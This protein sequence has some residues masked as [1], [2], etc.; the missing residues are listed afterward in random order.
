MT[1]ASAAAVW[2]RFCSVGGITTE[3]LGINA[4][5]GSP[6][7]QV[8]VLPG[9]PGSA[10]FFK[11]FMAAVHRQLRGRADVLALT[12]AGHDPE[13]DHGG[14]VWDLSQQINHKVSFLREHVL[15]PGKPPVLL[16]G[17]SIGAAMMIKAVAE[18]E[19]LSSASASSAGGG[20]Q[21]EQQ[22]GQGQGCVVGR[23]NPLADGP[24][25][26]GAEVGEL[27]TPTP[28]PT[29]APTPPAILKLVAVFPFFETNFRGSWRQRC[30]SS[31]A[32]W[33]EALGWA[34]AAV[35]SLPRALQLAFVRLGED[36]D[37][38]A[39]AL[40]ARLLSRRTVCNAFFLASHEFRDLSRPWDWGLMRVLGRRLHVMGCEADTWMSRQQYDNMLARVPG[41]Q[42]TWHP[43]LRHAF[44]VSER[45]S[46]AVAETIGDVARSISGLDLDLDLDLDVKDRMDLV[47]ARLDLDLD[48][49]LGLPAD[50]VLEQEIELAACRSPRSA[51]AASV[52]RAD[53]SETS[54]S[55]TSATAGAG[56]GTGT[57]NDDE[58]TT[59]TFATAPRREGKL[60]EV[61]SR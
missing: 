14:K 36:L 60:Q 45:Q 22:Q 61:E 24:V 53:S 57:A 15:L 49:R 20:V 43:D 3:L 50:L 23:A 38:D 31:L 41:L 35:S 51:S 17:H 2:Q 32:P 34:G 9:N 58:T 59:T 6:R 44:C 37:G 55:E 47:G 26:G 21:E 19:G 25:D 18:I 10:A 27:P 30:L 5:A 54:S 1:G 56:S 28:T 46:A 33:Y 29:P 7:L 4:T 39:A 12:H 16:L 52:S 13:T 11:P 40:T 42:A 8:V 48:L